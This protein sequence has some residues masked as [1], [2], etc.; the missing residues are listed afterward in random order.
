MSMTET[1]MLGF[2]ENVKEL[3]E[4]ERLALS[5]GGLDVEIIVAELGQSIEAA[6]AA[7][8]QQESFKREL[9]ASTQVTE[10]R[11]RKMYTSASGALD[12]AMG[13]I[14][15]TSSTAKNFQ[16]L[17]SG[18]K[19]RDEPATIKPVPVPKPTEIA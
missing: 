17:R 19:R 12:M 10:A 2:A 14:D 16:R 6:R 18:V 8:A 7:N 1:E 9:K 11:M 13:S 15:K 4:K 5:K 3:F